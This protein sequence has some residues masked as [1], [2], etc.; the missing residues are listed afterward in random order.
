MPSRNATN[1]QS[2]DERTVTALKARGKVNRL[3]VYRCVARAGKPQ[4]F[5]ELRHALGMP[6]STL[7]AALG[8]LKRGGLVSIE[9]HPDRSVAV[10]VDATDAT[11][12]LA[13]AEVIGCASMA[14]SAARA[15]KVRQQR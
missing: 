13:L 5:G 7:S 12:L 11:G 6:K 10:R 2:S 3:L 14:L 8:R 4:G 1:S 9:R 15:R